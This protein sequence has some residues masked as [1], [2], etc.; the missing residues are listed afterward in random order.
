MIV[1]LVMS[2]WGWKIL[3]RILEKERF[4]PIKDA[5][6]TMGGFVLIH[7]ALMI[8]AMVIAALLGSFIPKGI[9]GSVLSALL[10]V[11]P[12]IGG[13]WIGFKR[14][15]FIWLWCTAGVILFWLFLGIASSETVVLEATETTPHLLLAIMGGYF[16]DNMLHE[17]ETSDPLSQMPYQ[18]RD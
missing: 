11:I 6:I 7:F 8:L 13:C 14:N 1:T 12:F 16:A 4:L 5:I 3:W 2:V 17:E 9:R 15:Q 10:L 18:P